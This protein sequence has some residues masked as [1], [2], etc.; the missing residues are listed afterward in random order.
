MRINLNGAGF[1]W[2]IN[3]AVLDKLIEVNYENFHIYNSGRQCKLVQKRDHL[4]LI[5][6]AIC[7]NANGSGLPYIYNYMHAKLHLGV[8]VNKSGTVGKDLHTNESIFR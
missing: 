8:L 1:A 3:A 7:I 6:S 5:H 4:E 2:D